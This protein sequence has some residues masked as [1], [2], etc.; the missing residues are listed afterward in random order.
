MPPVPGSS[1]HGRGGCLR[2][3][4]ELQAPGVHPRTGGADLAGPSL[5]IS[6]L[7]FIPA[8][9]GRMSS[10]SMCRR[11]SRVHPRT[12]GADRRVFCRLLV[13]R[14][15]SPHGRGGSS[16]GGPRG[17]TPWFIPARAGRIGPSTRSGPVCP[18]SSPHGRGGSVRWRRVSNSSR[19]HPR[20]GGA[21]P[22]RSRSVGASRVHPR[23]GGADLPVV[24]EGLSGSGFIPARAGRISASSAKSAYPWVHPRTGGADPSRLLAPNPLDGFIPARAG[25]IVVLAR[26]WSWCPGSSPHGRGG[27]DPDTRQDARF[28]GSSPHGRGGSNPARSRSGPTRVHPRTGGADLDPFGCHGFGGGFIPARA[29]RIEGDHGE[30]SC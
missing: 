14:G 10:G 27:S 26:S 29:G 3:P 30:Y 4:E 5:D 11:S 20:T 18:G 25:R 9:A 22:I 16:A 1:P 6:G 23:T 19:V 21:D 24:V 2:E 28:A 15:S 17:R 13:V 12:G 8:R 7:G